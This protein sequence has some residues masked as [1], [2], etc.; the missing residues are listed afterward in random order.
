MLRGQERDPLN[1]WVLS[2]NSSKMV[3]VPDFEFV[4]VSIKHPKETKYSK[5][6]S[7]VTDEVT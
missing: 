1:L 2:I 6:C 7:H 4:S 5:S 3:K